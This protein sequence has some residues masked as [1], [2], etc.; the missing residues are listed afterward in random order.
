VFY[1][2]FH[3][4]ECAR[5][6]VP[7]D[8]TDSL[9]KQKSKRAAI[10]ITRLPAKVSVSDARYGGA[11]L[12]NP[13]GPGGSGI[14]LVTNQGKNLQTVV[15][16][17]NFSTSVETSDGLYFDIIGFDP[18]GVNNTTPT[19]SCF[20]D[21]GARQFWA[22][23]SQAQGL[24]SDNRTFPYV[25]GRTQALAESCSHILS[26]EEGELGRFVSTPNVVED[27]VAII[28]ALG[29]WREEKASSL[30]A[31]GK[32]KQRDDVIERTRWRKGNEQLLYW[33]FSY[34]TLLGAT[35]ATMHPKRVGR[36]VLDGVC[37]AK[38]Y[39]SGK[40]H[41]SHSTSVFFTT[42]ATSCRHNAA[43]SQANLY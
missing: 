29:K 26:H 16:S 17:G 41:K 15:D 25:Y 10:A 32:S 34:G 21:D 7:L 37:D 8:W 33:G 3:D 1:P 39:Y 38:D 43:I 14:G 20:P 24:L 27:M 40:F 30:L 28:E 36:L 4:F 23:Q 11:V 31:C 2:C 22:V 18:R 12:I 35:F 13:G 42:L 5:L 9:E 19:I 6:D